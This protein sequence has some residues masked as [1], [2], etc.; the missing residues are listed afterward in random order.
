[1]DTKSYDPYVINYTS[2]PFE[3]EPIKEENFESEKKEDEETETEKEEEINLTSE[4]EYFNPVNI[5]SYSK[6]GTTCLHEAIRCRN[7]RMVEFLLSKGADANQQIFDFNS[8]NQQQQ[9]K[10]I[11]NCLCEAI[12]PKVSLNNSFFYC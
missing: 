11:S 4:I 2:N 7:L 12:L 9:S 10:P 3:K 5:S 1:M 6:F 8:G